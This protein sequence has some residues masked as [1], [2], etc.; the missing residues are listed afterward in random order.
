MCFCFLD[1]GV[2]GFGVDGEEYVVFV[3]VTAGEKVY[4]LEE[5]VYLCVDFDLLVGFD[6]GGVFAVCFSVVVCCCLYFCRWLSRHE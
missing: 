2:V 4:F 5:A 1:S 6:C 3:D